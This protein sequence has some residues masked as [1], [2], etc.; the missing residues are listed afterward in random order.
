MIG[1]LVEDDITNFLSKEDLK[2]FYKNKDN[3][4]RLLDKSNL[5]SVEMSKIKNVVTTPNNKY[6]NG[7]K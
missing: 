7:E 6:Y 2:K 3:K 1:E 5:F 4:S